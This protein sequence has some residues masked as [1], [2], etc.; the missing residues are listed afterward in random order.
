MNIQTRPLILQHIYKSKAD[1]FTLGLGVINFGI[2]GNDGVADKI[3]NVV[4]EGVTYNNVQVFIDNGIW[5][6][7]TH[8][9]VRLE[10]YTTG[11]VFTIVP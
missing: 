11:E 1:E 2:S 4:V 9:F 3:E 5:F 10:N 8:G 7:K 6:S